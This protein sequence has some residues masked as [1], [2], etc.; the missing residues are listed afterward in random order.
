MAQDYGMQHDE[1]GRPFFWVGG[2]VGGKKNYVSPV[3]M[4]GQAPEDTT[5]IFRSRPQWNN[6]KGQW[7]TPIDWGNIATL[8]TGGAL[9][10]GALSAL[11]AFGGGAGAA[12]GAGSGAGG[13]LPSGSIAG[14]HT[15]VPTAIGSQGVS[16]GIGAGT[17]LGGV[18]PSGA[19]AGLHTAVPGAIGS[20]GVSAGIGAG[21]GSIAGAAGL[22][23]GLLDNLTSVKGIASL[24]SIIPALTSLARNNGGDSGSGGISD[25][26]IKQAYEDA[27][28]QNAMKEARY[29]R[30]DPL[31]E[32]VTQLA[33]SR[34]PTNMQRGPLPDVPLPK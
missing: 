5:G 7:E 34:M 33:Y 3:A 22:G 15:A 19:I 13:V 23:K 27:K 17:A 6:A 1:Q 10:A 4:G 8:A 25:D 21:A 24:A 32:A 12:G 30:V 26:F 28:R 29:R 20:E 14:L 18:L 2:Q 31:H 11:G 9:G 16:A